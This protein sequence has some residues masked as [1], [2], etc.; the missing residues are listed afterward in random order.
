M[1]R[2][3]CVA[4]GQGVRERICGGSAGVPGGRSR[5]LRKGN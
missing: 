3:P 2:D 1:P 4:R 5:L